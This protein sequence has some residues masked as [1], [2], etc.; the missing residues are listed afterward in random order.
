MIRIA[1]KRKEIQIKSEEF[2][3]DLKEASERFELF[4]KQQAMQRRPSSLFA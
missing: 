4:K 3:R 2:A 1:E